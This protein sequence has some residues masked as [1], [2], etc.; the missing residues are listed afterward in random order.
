M[1]FCKAN[2]WCLLLVMFEMGKSNAGAKVQ[3]DLMKDCARRRNT[4][5]GSGKRDALFPRD[6]I[7]AT[8]VF[9]A[10]CPMPIR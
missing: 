5:S 8:P 9:K 4:S 7:F 10:A 3:H 1:Y 6:N 2:V